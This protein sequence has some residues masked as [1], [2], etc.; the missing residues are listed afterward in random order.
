VATDLHV[1]LLLELWELAV[2][3]E[4][5]EKIVY[6]KMYKIELFEPKLAGG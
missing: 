5:V 2:D 1:P 3:K 4:G 6:S